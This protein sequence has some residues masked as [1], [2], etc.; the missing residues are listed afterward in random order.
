MLVGKW[1]WSLIMQSAPPQQRVSSSTNESYR[2][3]RTES[4]KAT[5]K[6]FYTESKASLALLIL[7]TQWHREPLW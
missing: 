4:Y 5:V 1:V 3:I 6:M 2:D 7:L